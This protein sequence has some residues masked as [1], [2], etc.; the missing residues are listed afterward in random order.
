MQPEIIALIFDFDITLSPEFQQQVIFD[1]WGVESERFWSESKQNMRRGY[2]M[3]HAYLKNFID[4]GR[5]DTA[6]ALT[7]ERLYAFGKKVKLYDGLSRRGGAHSVFDDLQAVL[8]RDEFAE[9]DIRLECYCVSGGLK[10]MIRGALEV[11]VLEG[12]FKEVFACTMDEDESGRL[13]FVKETVGHTIKT[14]KLYM[15]AKGVSPE[16]GD[17]PSDV[18]EVIPKLRIPFENMI[19]L[20][21][22]QTDIPAFSLVNKSGGTSIAVY[23]EEKD[24]GGIIDEQKT[25]RTYAQGYKLAI[26]SKRAEQLLPADYSSGKPLKMALLGYVEK[27]AKAIVSRRS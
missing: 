6:Y 14:Q 22:G 5:R 19:F 23:R 8:A 15:I 10:E 20:G 1:A 16:Q 18:N 17:D 24:A 7:N 2:D 13:G 9:H 4:Y 21:D 11:N 27:I 3:E 25:L 12:Y 26:E